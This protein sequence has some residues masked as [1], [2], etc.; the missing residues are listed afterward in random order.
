MFFRNQ[1]LLPTNVLHLPLR[2]RGF[3]FRNHIRLLEDSRVNFL[4]FQ[5]TSTWP[6]MLSFHNLLSR[7]VG[8]VDSS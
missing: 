3:E 7:S 4:Q 6:E 2:Y 5:K 8:T 1:L